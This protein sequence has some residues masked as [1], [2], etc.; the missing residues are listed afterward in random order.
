MKEPWL[1]RKQ[2]DYEYWLLNRGVAPENLQIDPLL[3]TYDDLIQTLI[4]AGYTENEDLFILIM[5][6]VPNQGASKAWN[7]IHD[8]WSENKIYK[9]IGYQRKPGQN[10]HQDWLKSPEAEM[11]TV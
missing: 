1:P 4:N 7:P 2:D 5:I 11:L 6:G 9:Y 10:A 8:Q 3:N